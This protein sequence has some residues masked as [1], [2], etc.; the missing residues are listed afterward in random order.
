MALCSSKEIRKAERSGERVVGWREK[1]ARVSGSSSYLN[2]PKHF[3]VLMGT[4]L[5]GCF[6]NGQISSGKGDDISPKKCEAQVELYHCSLLSGIDLHSLSHIE[7]SNYVSNAVD[8]CKFSQ[9]VSRRITLLSE[10]DIMSSC[11][12]F[13]LPFFLY[14]STQNLKNGFSGVL[15]PLVYCL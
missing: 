14:F 3:K 13:S 2:L 6:C 5:Q 10:C 9:C 7:L 1:C 15:S 8:F 4:R 11:S 12:Q